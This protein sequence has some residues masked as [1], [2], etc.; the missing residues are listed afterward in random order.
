MRAWKLALLALPLAGCVHQLPATALRVDAVPNFDASSIISSKNG[1]IAIDIAKVPGTV[2]VPDA[3]GLCDADGFLPAPVTAAGSKVIV[4]ATTNTQPSYDSL[5][6]NKYNSDATVPFV[7]ATGSSDRFNEIKAT[8]VATA[9]F[10]NDSPSSGYPGIEAIKAA[11]A[12]AGHDPAVVPFV[13]WLS[14]GNTIA[15]STDTFTKVSSDEHVTGTGIGAN[16]STYNNASATQEAVWIGVFAHKIGL[17]GG[18]HIGA[19]ARGAEE[20]LPV[21]KLPPAEKRQIFAV[22]KQGVLISRAKAGK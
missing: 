11:M 3:A 19:L 7:S 10:S 21:D 4:T 17:S 15:V 20:A 13:Y 16:G 1:I 6:D 2:C 5:V 22:D 12:A 8:T 14:A 18:G 9:T